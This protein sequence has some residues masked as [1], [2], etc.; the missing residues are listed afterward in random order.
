MTKDGKQMKR[1]TS[2]S[3]NPTQGG[4][5]RAGGDR[6]K[7]NLTPDSVVSHS[8]DAPSVILQ[9]ASDLAASL[10]G[11]RLQRLDESTRAS[12][13][14]P[15]YTYGG[16]QRGEMDAQTMYAEVKGLNTLEADQ[17]IISHPGDQEAIA[18]LVPFSVIGTSRHVDLLGEIVCLFVCLFVFLLE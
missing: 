5:V 6:W 1:S 15:K 13:R 9:S 12:V 11:G 4:A 18:Y 3:K 2:G 8:K 17:M 14:A 16:L 10:S 7:V